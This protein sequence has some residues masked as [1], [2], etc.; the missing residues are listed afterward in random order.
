MFLFLLFCFCSPEYVAHTTLCFVLCEPRWLEKYV[1]PALDQPNIDGIYTDC[2][3]GTAAEAGLPS[4]QII[5]VSRP[6]CCLV[7]PGMRSI[8][9]HK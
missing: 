3:C 4:S 5:P 1:G 9:P 8:H 2:S 7:P 6:S